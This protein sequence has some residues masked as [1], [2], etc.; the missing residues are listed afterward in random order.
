[1]DGDTQSFLYGGSSR[2][3]P[4]LHVPVAV[5]AAAEQGGLLC[6]GR[7]LVGSGVLA[8]EK[9]FTVAEE[10]AW[11]RGPLAIMCTVVLVMVLAQRAE[12]WWA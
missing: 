9:A 3:C 5:A 7:V 11:L 2:I 1:M 10:A 6:C 8:S 4:H 12:C